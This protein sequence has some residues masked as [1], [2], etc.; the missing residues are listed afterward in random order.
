M[1]ETR[2]ETRGGR[3]IGSFGSYLGHD[4]V[5]VRVVTLWLVG[6]VLFVGTWIASY[7]LLPER[8]LNGVVVSPGLVTESPD[9]W[10]IFVQLVV[11]NLV[12]GM[13]SIIFGNHFRIGRVPIGYIPPLFWAALYGA[14]LGTNSFDVSAGGKIAPTLAV[15]W[16]RSG[17]LE[18]TAYLILAAATVGL[19]VWQKSSLLARTSEKVR[20][21]RDVPLNRWEVVLAIFAFVLLGIANWQEAADIVGTLVG[22]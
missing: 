13:G 14:F 4:N 21:V 7:Y 12:L 3:R 19:V 5:F 8:A 20:R 2:T 1:S 11:V 6:T 22:S 9:A 10:A 17:V 16:T 15:V 18:I